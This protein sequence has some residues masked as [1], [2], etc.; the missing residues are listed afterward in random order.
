VSAQAYVEM[1]N[2]AALE[3]KELLEEDIAEL[4]VGSRVDIGQ[5]VKAT[6]MK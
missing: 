5:A 6:Q 1:S 4:G 3:G 2:N